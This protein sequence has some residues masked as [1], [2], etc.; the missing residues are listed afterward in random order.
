MVTVVSMP[1]II[2]GS[3]VI[4]A[5]IRPV[6][7]PVRI[8][9]T[10]RRIISV[11]TWKSEPDIEVN[12]SIRTRHS[13]ERETTR[14]ECNQQKFLHFHLPV[15]KQGASPKVSRLSARQRLWV[16]DY[17]D[18]LPDALIFKTAE[19]HGIGSFCCTLSWECEHWS[20]SEDWAEINLHF[21]EESFV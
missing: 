18:T 7:I 21:V 1:P 6:V 15:I 10:V 9:I 20:S 5:I 16:A 3:I 13:R 4:A 12:L 11:I 17:G 2:I 14:H 8:V 19:P